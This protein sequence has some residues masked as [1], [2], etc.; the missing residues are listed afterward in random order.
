MSK[1]LVDIRVRQREYLLAISRALSDELELPDVLRIILQASVEFAG[2]RSGLIVLSDPTDCVFRVAAALGITSEMLYGHA[3]LINGV[4]FVSGDEE[5][6]VRQIDEAISSLTKKIVPDQAIHQTLILPLKSRGIITGMIY[7]FQE[8]K[9]VFG[10]DAPQ[11]LQAF[12]DQAAIAVKNA[13]LYE[14]INSEKQRLDAI[15][16]NSVDGIMILDPQLNIQ[17]FNRALA[18]ITGKKASQVLG[19]HH[20]DL[21]RWVTLRTDQELRE[22]VDNGWPLPGSANLY[23]EGDLLPANGDLVSLGITYTPLLNT[24]GRL[25]N[26]IANVRDLTRFRREEELQK[27]FISV[28]S[29]EL[30]TPVSIIKGYAGTLKRPDAKWTPEARNEYLTVIEEEADSLTDLID[31]LLEASKLQAGSFSLNLKDHICLVSLAKR[32]AKKFS[33]QTNDH[34]I[35]VD[36]PPKFPEINADERR[37]N[38][39]LNN[40]V[41]N[42]IKYSPKGGPIEIS[43]TIED[44]SRYVTVSVTDH[45]IGIPEH[46]R[47]RIFQKFS[48]LDNDLSRKTEG[49]GLGLFLTK[50]IVEA[51]GGRIWF[52]SNSEQ[53]KGDVG[54]TFAF[55]LP[56]VF[57]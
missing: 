8:E 16:E 7:V 38:Q 30:K 24:R 57:N 53:N 42:A 5:V 51:H 15:I 6:A 50:A 33:T 25:I 41:S 2:G 47:H 27:T 28:V 39:V 11:L 19:K 9:Y 36:F 3:D 44:D 1:S 12:A 21:V 52:E 29:H 32:A 35:F 56:N 17:V 22:A 18:N 37:I 26:I 31:N 13:R 48:R 34:E 49:T 23:V 4:H 40:L 46:E 43:G 14:E 55:S 20:D 10:D 54:T 45:G